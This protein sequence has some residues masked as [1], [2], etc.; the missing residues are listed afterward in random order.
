[1]TTSS[2]QKYSNGCLFKKS[3]IG[4]CILI[5]SIVFLAATS[6][7]L[8]IQAKDASYMQKSIEE[9]YYL[10]GTYRVDNSVTKISFVSDDNQTKIAHVIPP[11][12]NNKGVWGMGNPNNAGNVQRGTYRV[13]NDPNIYNLYDKDNNPCGF[14]HLAYVNPDSS[15]GTLYVHLIGHDVLRLRKESKIIEGSLVK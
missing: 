5:G 14:A 11:K 7:W 6:V 3:Y 2:S 13:S 9:G 10:H 8:G 12:E 4:Y 1:M 15:S